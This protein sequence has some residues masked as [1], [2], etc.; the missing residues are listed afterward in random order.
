ML[1]SFQETYS[2]VEFYLSFKMMIDTNPKKRSHEIYVKPSL[3][4]HRFS[5]KAD[6]M[7]Y[8]RDHRKFNI[9][10]ILIAIKCKGMYRRAICAIKTSK[11]K[12]STTIRSSCLYLKLDRSIN[13]LILISFGAR[14]KKNTAKRQEKKPVE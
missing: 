11:N 5:S 9:L 14:R 4:A 6:L 1:W 3:L 8:L 13:L 7:T 10:N 12:C 2:K